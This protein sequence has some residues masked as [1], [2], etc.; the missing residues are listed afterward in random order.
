MR[1]ALRT[2]LNPIRAYRFRA[3]SHFPYVTRPD[4]YTAL[5]REVLGL[6]GDHAI[7]PTGEESLS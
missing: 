6:T 4:A 2:A 7:W 1:S 5:L 3:A